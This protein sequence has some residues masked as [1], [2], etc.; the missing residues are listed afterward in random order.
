MARLHCKPKYRTTQFMSVKIKRTTKKRG[1]KPS[2]KAL[3]VRQLRMSDEQAEAVAEWAKAQ[4]DKPNWSE[5]VRRLVEQSLAGSQPQRKRSAESAA[6][7]SKM[8]HRALDSLGD[9]SVP[10]EER[11]SRKRRLTKGPREFRE[12]RDDLSKSKG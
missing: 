12:M 3:P 11:E 4:D 8:A 10:L 7:A 2:G 1:P 6:E 5:A 9:Q